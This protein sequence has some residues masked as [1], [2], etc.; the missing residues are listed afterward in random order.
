MRGCDMPRDWTHD[1]ELSPAEIDV[2]EALDF[3]LDL[4]TSDAPSGAT[5]NADGPQSDDAGRTAR[6]ASV[7]DDLDGPHDRRGHGG[8]GYRARRSTT[9][10]AIAVVVALTSF[11][12]GTLS[13]SAS[14]AAT[15]LGCSAMVSV[16]IVRRL[17][18]S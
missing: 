2:L 5:S 9:L 10:A 14:V 1:T 4:F 7:F 12:L 8:A 11:V 6:S 16:V 17:R 13:P 15:A 18:R 3:D